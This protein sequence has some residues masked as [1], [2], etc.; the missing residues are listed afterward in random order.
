MFVFDFGLAG[1]YLSSGHQYSTRLQ[2]ALHNKQLTGWFTH[3]LLGALH[4]GVAEYLYDQ[5]QYKGVDLAQCASASSL[6]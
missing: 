3:D 2:Q 5:C 4:K 1:T 6:K